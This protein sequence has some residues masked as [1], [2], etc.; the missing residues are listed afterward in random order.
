MLDICSA[1]HHFSLL[2]LV[3]HPVFFRKIQVFRIGVF[4]ELFPV[5][6]LFGVKTETVK[7]LLP[8][9]IRVILSG[10]TRFRRNRLQTVCTGLAGHARLPAHAML[11]RCRMGLLGRKHCGLKRRLS[12]TA[13]VRCPYGRLGWFRL[14][15]DCRGNS[16]LGSRLWNRLWSSRLYSIFRLACPGC[17][18]LR[19]R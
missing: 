7:R 13:S 12:E 3:S 1:I 17:R 6:L 18:R 15:I 9:G 5:I 19:F 8:V 2:C 11:P 4:P 16:L 14:V 10:E